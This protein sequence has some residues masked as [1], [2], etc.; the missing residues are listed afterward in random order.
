MTTRTKGGKKRAKGVRTRKPMRMGFPSDEES[1]VLRREG[2]TK[3]QAKVM[4]IETHDDF[5]GLFEVASSQWEQPYVVEIRNLIEPLNSCSCQ[6]YRM[7]QLGSCKHIERVLQ[8]V[9][10]RKKRLFARAAQEGSTCYEVYMDVRFNPPRLRL[11][12][13]ARRS[14]AIDSKL[15]PLFDVEGIGLGESPDT[16]AA[17]ERV[18]TGLSARLRKRVRISRHADYWLE[19]ERF[20]LELADLH[21][22]FK[23]DEAAGKRSDN[24]VNLPLYPYQRQGMVHLAFTGRALLADEMGLGKTVQALAAAE[25]LRQLGKV[26]RVL[27]V[28]PASLKAEWEDQLA[29]FTGQR[30]KSIFGSRADRMRA[31]T[32]AHAF[33]VCNY[34]QIR[35]DV[36]DINRLLVPDHIILDEAQRIKNWPT[37]TAKTIKRL[38]SPFAF[39]LTGTPLE[40][41]IEEL[42]SLVEFIDPHVFGSLFRFQRAYIEMTADNEFRPKNL[43]QLHRTVSTVMLRRRKADVE[44]S[45]PERTDKNF[46]VSMTKEQRVRY[47]EFEYEVAKLVSIMKRRP[48]IKR[49][50]EHLQIMLGCMRMTCDTPYILDQ[51]CRDCPK[52]EELENI[53]DEVLSVADAKVIIFSEWVRM[54]DLIKELLDAKRIGYA[55]HTGKIPQRQRR[56][57]IRRFKTDADCRVFLSSE[58]GG[59]GLNLQAANIVINVDLPW[60]PAKLEQRIARA[61]RKHQQRSVRVINLVAENS[62][63][64]GMLDKLAYKTAL[65]DSVLD[66][67]EFKEQPRS[68]AGRNAFAARVGELLGG[69]P[70]AAEK[71]IEK[72]AAPRLKEDLIARH[73]DNIIGI[74]QNPKTGASIVVVRPGVNADDVR[75]TAQGAT[76]VAAEILTPDVL[77]LLRR[78][79][80]EGILTLSSEMDTLHAA[81]GYMPLRTKKAEAPRLHY[82]A[83]QKMWAATE[84]ERK[85]A[86]TLS[87]VGLAEQ[88]MPHLSAAVQKGHE[89]IRVLCTG[90]SEAVQSE[91]LDMQGEPIALLADLDAF[92]GDADGSLDDRL[93]QGLDLVERVGIAIQASSGLSWAAA[94]AS[95]RCG[96]SA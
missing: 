67:A 10:H 20:H 5:H 12:L 96:V 56:E 74:E 64:S 2:A 86:E 35:V 37:K 62:I 38:Q 32:E 91:Q 29:Q 6:D 57:Q 19:R 55:E 77:D 16:W 93:R 36:D 53:L 44:D 31:Y 65:A 22:R 28:C 40:N 51:T 11:L 47:G 30:A 27:V 43:D 52:L 46:F 45:L 83:A 21:D 48:L 17:L 60:N 18:V 73:A 1:L 50:H 41:R 3:E 92:L 59:T 14:T 69:E 54:L 76:G 63:E 49:E 85:A 75:H 79:Q 95:A 42:Y 61:W 4:C 88:A 90:A 84:S 89:T 87:R 70:S 8:F 39:V 78:L 71:V 68:E 25:L 7:S 82:K 94:A 33:C 80:E 72:P 9:G 23:R 34:E 15:M 13:P 24:P 26:R 66:G 81:E 58:S